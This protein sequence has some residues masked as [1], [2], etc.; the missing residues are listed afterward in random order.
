[1]TILPLDQAVL[2]F[3][4]CELTFRLDQGEMVHPAMVETRNPLLATV[5]H[6]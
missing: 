2:E 6:R 5:L 4:I 1:M 3:T